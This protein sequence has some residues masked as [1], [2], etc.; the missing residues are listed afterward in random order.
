MGDVMRNIG[1]IMDKGYQV[2]MYAPSK[3]R[4]FDTI[5]GTGFHNANLHI[6]SSYSVDY[7][8]PEVQRFV[9]AYRALYNAEPNGFSFQGYD[10]ACFFVGKCS[11]YG[12]RWMKKVP[13]EKE[14][15]LHTDFCM[16]ALET[17]SLV[18]KAVRRTVYEK[19]FSTH[20][21]K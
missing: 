20:L 17:G 13:G 7:S 2:V 8:L 16:E 4:T 5:D 14:S 12:N 3:L 18:N 9:K 19:D 15:L 11:K 21:V 1:I 10:T 6:S